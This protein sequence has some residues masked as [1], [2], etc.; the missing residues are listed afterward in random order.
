VKATSA[1]TAWLFFGTLAASALAAG[2]DGNHGRAIRDDTPAAAPG[3]FEL[4]SDP[5]RL[6]EELAV[7][8]PEDEVHLRR[9]T[10]ARVKLRELG[11]AAFPVLVEH[12]N[13][14]RASWSPFQGQYDHEVMV[15]DVCAD[16]VSE[17]IEDAEVR[18]LMKGG[19]FRLPR[20]AVSWWATR[21]G[22]TLDQLRREALQSLIENVR[23]QPGGDPRREHLAFLE[24]KLEVYGRP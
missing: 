4:S 2:C 10:A 16:I 6:I 3:R 14:R 21:K 15:G 17:H 12:A 9:A 19:Y 7:N 5:E 1:I 18:S 23:N 24:R 13:D 20:D 11:I 8:G 22:S